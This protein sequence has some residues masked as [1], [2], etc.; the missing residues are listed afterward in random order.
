MDC[1]NCGCNQLCCRDECL[2]VELVLGDIFRISDFLELELSDFFNDYVIIKPL[3]LPEL[4]RCY[5][6][7]PPLPTPCPFLDDKKCKIQEV[8][9]ITC[10]IFPKKLIGLGEVNS[11]FRHYYPCLR[12]IP[13]IEYLYI[14]EF[15]KIY[16]KEY[17]LLN[18]LMCPAGVDGTFFRGCDKEYDEVKYE[19]PRI[20]SETNNPIERVGLI[21]IEIRKLITPKLN[22][23]KLKF[24]VMTPPLSLAN[25]DVVLNF[26]EELLK[27]LTRRESELRNKCEDNTKNYFEIRKK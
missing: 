7:I 8:K 27:E 23:Q 2:N 10:I 13:E 21:E 4:Q 18:K 11:T 15:I 6:P 17:S 22:S 24:G 9:P 14:E 25:K 26:R 16:L 1:E 19:I 12:D 5:S 3:F 20:M